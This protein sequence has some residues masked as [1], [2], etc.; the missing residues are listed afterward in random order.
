PSTAAGAATQFATM[1]LDPLPAI[2]APRRARPPREPPRAAG[3]LT[4]FLSA[5]ERAKVPFARRGGMEAVRPTQ[6]QLG[7][8]IT[9]ERGD[10]R[11]YR[12]VPATGSERHR[13]EERR[14]QPR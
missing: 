10:R 13:R 14:G 6:H 11:G 4:L 7:T 2:S 3:F 8:E 12:S 5:C 9:P 1:N